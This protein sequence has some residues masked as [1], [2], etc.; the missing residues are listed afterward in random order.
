MVQVFSKDSAQELS[1]QDQGAAPYSDGKGH[2]IVQIKDGKAYL[3][4]D[5]F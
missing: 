1:A 2:T 5:R 4:K 3:R